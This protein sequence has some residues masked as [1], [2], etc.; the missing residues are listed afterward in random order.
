[1]TL[2]F[3]GC[4]FLGSRRI[5]HAQHDIAALGVPAP[6]TPI[7]LLSSNAPTFNIDFP[8]LRTLTFNPIIGTVST[9]CPCANTKS[10]VV[11]PL[12][13]KEHF[14]LRITRMCKRKE[15]ICQSQGLSYVV[16][17][18]FLVPARAM[19][20]RMNGGD[21]TQIFRLLSHFSWR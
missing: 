9:G 2:F 8:F 1:V 5:H 20:C 16:S 13:K 11:F 14:G 17:D 4:H 12:L 18:L 7:L 21:S 6:L 10:S 19:Q 3:S 15:A